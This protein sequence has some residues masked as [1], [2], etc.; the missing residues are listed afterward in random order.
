M[1]GIPWR[2]NS[3]Y[4]AGWVPDPDAKIYLPPF[5]PT[6]NVEGR[7]EAQESVQFMCPFVSALRD[8]TSTL[9]VGGRGSATTTRTTTM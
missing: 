7:H 2:E 3:E 8:T 5:P 4:H 9:N 6:F 1:D